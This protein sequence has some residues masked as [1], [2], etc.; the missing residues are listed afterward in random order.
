MPN[1]LVPE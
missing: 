1:A